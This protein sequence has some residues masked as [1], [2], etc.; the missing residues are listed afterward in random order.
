MICACRILW[1]VCSTRSESKRI[2]KR[3]YYKGVVLVKCDKCS[4][5]HIIADNLNWFDDLNGA[6]NIEDILKAKGEH[7][8]KRTLHDIVQLVNT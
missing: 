2:S 8:D 5:H 4:N 6:R 7:V 3:A 1:Q